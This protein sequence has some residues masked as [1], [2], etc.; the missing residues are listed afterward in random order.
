MTISKRPLIIWNFL[1]NDEGVGRGFFK[2]E[3]GVDM[4][5]NRIL[6]AA[7]LTFVS[8]M[9]LAQDNQAKVR[10]LVGQ[11]IRMNGYACPA[12]EGATNYGN[13]AYGL[14]MKVWCGQADRLGK[15]IYFRVTQSAN[16]IPGLGYPNITVVPWHD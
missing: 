5:I 7:S 6:I 15:P 11:L 10:D 2:F 13:D 4:R 1:S 16:K 14:V 12:V 3:Q 8:T 9:A